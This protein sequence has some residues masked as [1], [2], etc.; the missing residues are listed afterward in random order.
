MKK[1]FLALFFLL[2]LSLA[3]TAGVLRV[4]V[5]TGTHYTYPTLGK[6]FV[7]QN[8]TLEVL[9]PPMMER[10]YDQVCGTSV[11]FTLPVAAQKIVVYQNGLR[12]HPGVDYELQGSKI[13]PIWTWPSDSSVT[14]DYDSNP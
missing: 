9:L 10:H 1:T 5:W 12:Q 4:P 7:L 3:Q 6:S 14:C 11:S 8:S 2:T 13:V